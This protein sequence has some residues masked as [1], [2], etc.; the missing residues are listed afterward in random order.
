MGGLQLAHKWTNSGCH[1][2]PWILHVRACYKNVNPRTYKEGGGG[3]GLLFGGGLWLPP[4]SEVFLS[5]SQDDKTTACEAFS[6]C[7]FIPRAH[8][9]DMTPLKNLERGI[10]EKMSR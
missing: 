5:F 3:G 1:W 7:S 10:L 6:S 2:R 4:P 9:R 8:L